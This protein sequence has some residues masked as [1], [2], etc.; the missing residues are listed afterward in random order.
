MDN[1]TPG[2]RPSTPQGTAEVHAHVAGGPARGTATA[3]STG[4]GQNESR[5]DQAKDRAHDMAGQV[6]ERASNLLGQA[7]N[8]ASGL[9]DQAQNTLEERGVTSWIRER[10]LAA[11]GVAV[12]LGFVLAGSDNGSD[13][14]NSTF[15]KAKHQLKGAIMGGLSAAVAQEARSLIGMSGKGGAGGILGSLFSQQQ[16]GSG[17]SQG[18]TS[19]PAL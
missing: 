16:G 3:G 7:Q 18:G 10:P 9:L 4:G 5:V 1:T 17:T 6:Q 19:T 13:D 11:F 15:G 2:N 8:R 14:P 12:G